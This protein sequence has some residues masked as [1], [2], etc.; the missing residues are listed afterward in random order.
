MEL[1]GQIKLNAAWQLAGSWQQ[2]RA[3]FSSGVYAGNRPPHVAQRQL[4]ARLAWQPEAA[5]RIE[6]A[7]NH[8]GDSI[9]GNDWAN[10]CARRVPART[11]LDLN[12]AFSPPSAGWSVSAGVD[13]L[14]DRQS[15]GWGFT[16]AAC[17]ATN[18]YPEP[19]RSF[20][21]KARYSF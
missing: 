11:T 20:K 4:Q 8:R 7:L 21:L 16:N 18:V 19:G 12:Y 2:L 14:T 5:H 1:E 17:S 3:R 9:V 10:A 15:F 13:N 6:L